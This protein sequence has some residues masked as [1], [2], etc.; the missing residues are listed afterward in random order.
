MSTPDVRAA[1]QRKDGRVRGRGVALRGRRGERVVRPRARRTPLRQPP[2]W[3]PPT[4]S[5]TPA[6]PVLAR[7]PPAP[8]AAAPPSLSDPAR[9]RRPAGSEASLLPPPSSTN[10]A[11][12]RAVADGHQS[13]SSPPP[14]PPDPTSTTTGASAT[15]GAPVPPFLAPRVLS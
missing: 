14:R 13:P 3:P 2:L 15:A 6:P 12:G 8:Q 1:P 10:G 7:G 9:P 11:P 5:F 4:Q